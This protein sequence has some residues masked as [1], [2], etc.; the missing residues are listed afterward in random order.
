MQQ[1]YSC[2][3]CGSPVAFG[4]RFCTSC[5]TTLN[6]P[7]QQQMQPPPM[8]R[9]GVGHW[10][11]NHKF[12]TSVIILFVLVNILGLLNLLNTFE[13]GRLCGYYIF[14]GGLIWSIQARRRGLTM[15]TLGS[16]LLR[17]GGKRVTGG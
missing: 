4:A 10:I 13:T 8:K 1:T 16:L 11:R 3:N 9:R 17:G 12:W 2:P 15:I 6:W 14:L 7:T 5:G